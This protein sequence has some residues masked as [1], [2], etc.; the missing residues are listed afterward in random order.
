MN[1]ETVMHLLIFAGS[2]MA[3]PGLFRACR[4]FGRS[5]VK[6]FNPYTTIELTVEQPDGTYA[7]ERI[8]ISDSDALVEKLLKAKKTS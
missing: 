4:I 3:A 1:F 8:K 6:Y 2:L 5:L 7:T